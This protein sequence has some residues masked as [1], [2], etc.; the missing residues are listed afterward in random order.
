META[1]MDPK[2]GVVVSRDESLVPDHKCVIIESIDDILYRLEAR[3]DGKPGRLVFLTDRVRDVTGFSAEEFSADPDLWKRLLHPEDRSAVLPS[4]QKCIQTRSRLTRV[5][6]LQKRDGS[7]AWFEDRLVPLLDE[8]GDVFA[9]QGIAREITESKRT[10]EALRTANER[11]ELANS[12]VHS[13]IY[14]W[15]IG[16]DHIFWSSGLASVFGHEN[17]EAQDTD[18]WWVDHVHPAD[19][20]RVLA[21]FDEAID[22][23]ADIVLEYRFR[24]VAGLYR[25][26]LDRG[27]M[28]MDKSGRPHRIVGSILDI[29]ELKTA[30]DASRH[31]EARLQAIVN[32]EPECVKIVNPEGILLEMNPAGL[33]MIGASSPDQ[34]IGKAIMSLV[35]PEDLGS[36]VDFHRSVLSGRSGVTEFRMMDLQGKVHW[37]ESN[38]V[39]L[40]AASGEITAV[41]SVTREITERKQAL[42]ALAKSEERY[43]SLITQSCEGI[44]VFEP[45]SKRIQEANSSFCDLLGYTEEELRDLTL[46]DIVAADKESVDVNVQNAVESGKVVI[47]SRPYR[48][49]NGCIIDVEIRASCILYGES[50]VILVNVTDITDRKRAELLQSALYRVA[51]K[52]STA[53]DLSEFYRAIHGIVGEL[54]YAANFYIALFNEADQTLSFPYFA[55]EFDPPPPPTSLGKGLTEYTLRT[56]VPQFV[57]PER[58]RQLVEAGE[59]EAVGTDSLD[60]IG[61]PLLTGDKTFGVLVVQSY[62]QSHRYRESDRDVLTFVSQHI[63]SALERK[64]AEET[65]RHQA[66]HDGLTHLPNRM[67]FRDRFTQA[68]ARAH[69]NQELLAML[70]LDLDRFKTINDT[71]GHVVGDRL[72]QLVADRLANCLREGDTVARL[73]GDEFMVMLTGLRQPEDVA[74]VA[75]KLL[76]SVRPPFRIDGHELHVTTSIGISLYPYDGDNADILVKN[77]DI[78]L[79]RAKDAGRNNYQH[80]TPAMN[81]RA[82][83]QLTMENELRGALERNEF[84]MHYQPLID[85]TTGRTTSVEALVRWQHPEGHLVYPSEF[86][87]LTEDNGLIVPLGEWVLREACRQ[88]RHWQTAGLPAVGVSVNLSARQF[89]QQDL[90]E[91]VDEVLKDTKLPPSFL[92]LEL[93]ESILMHNVDAVDKTLHELKGMGIGISIDDFGMGYSSLSYLKRFPIGSLKI[94]QSF[95]RDCISDQDDAAIVT[96]IISM[97]HSLKMRVIAE[98]VETQ[99]QLD[100]LRAQRCDVVQGF[101]FSKPVAADAAADF[102]VRER[103]P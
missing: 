47:A 90:V 13:A 18:A 94:D 32:S 80:Y 6:R 8:N 63:A 15:D 12:A 100:F 33:R 11:F 17:Q 22:K 86:V 97:A 10:E 23:K 66:Y 54:M 50:Q 73:G 74:K 61:V 56:G 25:W 3:S 62:N 82:F 77:A 75:R 29:T 99:A 46:Y 64:R 35:H 87:P 39:P 81:A 101:L 43:R 71:L 48:R 98:G 24:N 68:L 53:Q 70:F 65:I 34:V 96:A 60:W 52:T 44:F 95:V 83:E 59:V 58:F 30:E 92:E 93:T 57:P 79:Y 4:V 72:L 16:S 49:K 2:G 19:R 14:E 28:V 27:R 91:T 26:V 9:L 84:V 102:L 67:L 78:A 85:L 21:A 42:E 1:G 51:E 76:H 7:Y 69:R 55:D 37:M 5:Y 103:R 41:L 45:A 31:N 40:R 38:S 88:N 89:Q 20:P 36:F